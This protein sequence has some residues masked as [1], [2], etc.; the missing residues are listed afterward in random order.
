MYFPYMRRAK[1]D[2]GQR[3]FRQGIRELSRH[4]P[5][6][7]VA[8][9]RDSVSACP[10]A[11]IDALAKASYWLAIAELRLDKPEQ[12]LQSLSTS[13]RLRPRGF[14]A[15]V[16]ARRVNCYGMPRRASPDLDN[17]YAFYSIQVCL[18]LGR[19]PGRRFSSESEKDTVTR[20]VSFAWQNLKASGRLAALEPAQR[21]SLFRDWP[22]VFPSF[23]AQGSSLGSELK[24]EGQSACAK[25][26]KEA[27]ILEFR[28]GHAAKDR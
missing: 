1:R 17:F 7:A 18:F 24:G 5:D 25:A 14:G 19:K 21:L 16:Y 11:K 2:E 22:G 3:A 6:K 27:V 12:A 26:C 20:L 23:V 13:R 15:R 28:R 4:R 8:I 10:A 9:L